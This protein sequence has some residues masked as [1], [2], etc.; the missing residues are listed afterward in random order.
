MLVETLV[1]LLRPRRYFRGKQRLLNW[2]LPA[3]GT[4]SACIFGYRMT[5]DISEYVQR[6]IYLG[7]F[8]P[9][10]TD[11]VLRY[12]RPG[13]TVVDGGANVGYYTALA[14]RCV[15]LSGRVIA[16]EPSPYAFGKLL[17][18]VHH[19]GLSQVT[20]RPL[21]LSNREEILCLFVPPDAFHQHDPSV[22]EYVAGMKP[23]SVPA[24]T[25]D[26]EAAAL[27]LDY[28]DLLKLDVE[29]HE[30]QVLA[31]AE[32]LL[33]AGKVG[34]VLCEFNRSLTEMNGGSITRLYELLL[35]SGFRDVLG[36]PDFSVPTFNRMLV[37]VR[38]AREAVR[39]FNS[40]T[41]CAE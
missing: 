24:R 19:N 16:F 18:L 11:L 30:L 2:V 40:E 3:E 35:G 17:E 37:S 36:R 39:G 4:K 28:I 22:V 25:L 32:G 13:M 34:A 38:C 15:G 26:A 9:Q 8:E 10:E 27:G 31:G 5:L 41:V 12:L 33:R 20:C 23:I 1:E 6:N 14:A 7:S 21:A 29:G